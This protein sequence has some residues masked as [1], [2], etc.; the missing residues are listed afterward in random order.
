MMSSNTH[1][2]GFII[3]CSTIAIDFWPKQDHPNITHYFL[4]HCHTDHT[5]NLDSKWTRSRIYCSRLTKNLLV[6]LKNVDKDIIVDLELNTTHVMN[7]DLDET[8]N[9]TL[10]DANHC[11]GAVMFLF[12]G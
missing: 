5:K 3:N 12:E 1:Y 7:I 8:F 2:P 4:T 6:D 9:V 10:I 11:P